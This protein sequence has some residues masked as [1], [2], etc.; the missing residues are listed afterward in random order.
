MLHT[1][2]SFCGRTYGSRRIHAGANY[3]GPSCKQKAYRARKLQLKKVKQGASL[4]YPRDAVR[5][6]SI[7]YGEGL[8]YMLNQLYAEYGGRALGMVIEIAQLVDLDDPDEKNSIY[9]Q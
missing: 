1:T 2:C 9:G 5:D 8:A 7:R 4:E 3:C 6:L